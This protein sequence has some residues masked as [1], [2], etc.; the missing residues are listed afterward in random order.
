MAFM[1]DAAV[2]RGN[3]RLPRNPGIACLGAPTKYSVLL[4][5]FISAFVSLT[6]ISGLNSTK[7][8]AQLALD[9]S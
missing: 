7:G 2:K 8:I 9:V 1:P 6:S 4:F 5:R 3:H